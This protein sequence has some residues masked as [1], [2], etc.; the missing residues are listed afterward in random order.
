M[1]TVNTESCPLLLTLF[2]PASTI[3]L[4]EMRGDLEYAWAYFY[5]SD[6]IFT[7]ASLL[8]PINNT[9]APPF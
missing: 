8:S 7:Q 2:S 5:M 1:S 9:V 4:R 6:E 3:A